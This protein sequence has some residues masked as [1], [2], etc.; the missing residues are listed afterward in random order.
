MER[1][2]K[3]YLEKKIMTVHV[4]VNPSEKRPENQG[5]SVISRGLDR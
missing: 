5:K 2:G 1:N 4:T 3:H